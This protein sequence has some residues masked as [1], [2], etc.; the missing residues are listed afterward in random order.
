MPDTIAKYKKKY[1]GCGKLLWH[2]LF[3]QHKYIEQVNTIY[4]YIFPSTNRHEKILLIQVESHDL[5][6]FTFCTYTHSEDYVFDRSKLKSDYLKNCRNKSQIWRTQ[7]SHVDGVAFLENRWWIW[8]FRHY[9]WTF[10]LS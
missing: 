4:F 1:A 7:K 6:T 5:R 9:I 3:C 10:L 2:H 8:I